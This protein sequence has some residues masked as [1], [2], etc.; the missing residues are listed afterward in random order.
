MLCRILMWEGRF[1]VF[2]T[3]AS[4][5]SG[6]RPWVRKYPS[7]FAHCLKYRRFWLKVFF[8]ELLCMYLVF[9][10]WICCSC[11]WV[12]FSGLKPTKDVRKRCLSMSFDGPRHMVFD[13]YRLTSTIASRMILDTDSVDVLDWPRLI[14]YSTVM[15][16]DQSVEQSESVEVYCFFV[17]FYVFYLVNCFI[18]IYISM[19]WSIQI[20]SYANWGI[21]DRRSSVCEDT[22]N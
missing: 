11:F 21:E 15:H 16:R 10:G 5:F 22:E 14:P 1:C 20:G 2:V 3:V 4:T 7:I 12:F 13:W 18:L 9:S 8:D 19:F 17:E 6:F